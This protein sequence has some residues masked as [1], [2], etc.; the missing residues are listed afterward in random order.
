MTGVGGEREMA[1]LA[2]RRRRLE[3][4][5]RGRLIMIQQAECNAI[6]KPPGVAWRMEGNRIKQRD[7]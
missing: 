4:A 2:G 7:D 1:A 6:D 5:A 3:Q